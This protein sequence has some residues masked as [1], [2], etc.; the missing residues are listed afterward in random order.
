MTVATGNTTK[1]THIMDAFIALPCNTIYSLDTCASNPA[2][3]CTMDITFAIPKASKTNTTV[4]KINKYRRN[5]F[6]NKLC[7]LNFVVSINRG[8]AYKKMATKKL[9]PTEIPD[10]NISQVIQA[11]P[12]LHPKP[13]NILGESSGSDKNLLAMHVS[14]PEIKH[15]RSFVF[16]FLDNH[17]SPTI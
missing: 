6:L 11:K 10:P 7:G 17:K 1:T 13:A 16:F 2:S 3:P 12:H 9:F 15:A 4:N 5:F 8:K 14:P